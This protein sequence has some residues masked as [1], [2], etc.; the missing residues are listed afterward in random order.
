MDRDF[1]LRKSSADVE[2][3]GVTEVVR[4]DPVCATIGTIPRR[5]TNMFAT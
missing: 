5:N 1:Y 3:G 2:Q 4:L